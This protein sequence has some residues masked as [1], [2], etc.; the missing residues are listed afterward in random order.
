MT[1]WYIATIHRTVI[2][3]KPSVQDRPGLRLIAGRIVEVLSLSGTMGGGP[4]IVL[5]PA[6]MGTAVSR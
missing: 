2:P 5:G 3:A 4:A 1:D 6:D